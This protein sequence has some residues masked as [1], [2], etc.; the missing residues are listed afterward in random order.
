MVYIQVFRFDGSRKVR[1]RC[2]V[3]VCVESCPPV[4]QRIISNLLL[5][6]RT[7]KRICMHEQFVKDDIMATTLPTRIL[8]AVHKKVRSFIM[9]VMIAFL[10]KRAD[11]L[12]KLI[13]VIRVRIK[14][15]Y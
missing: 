5:F 2:T 3:D 14:T 13:R 12:V 6:L 7:I 8:H 1:I 11:D 15:Q 10:G 4:R 9:Q